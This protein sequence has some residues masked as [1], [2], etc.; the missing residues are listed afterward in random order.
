M[1]SKIQT[2]KGAEQLSKQYNDSSAPL[3]ETRLNLWLKVGAVLLVVALVV[4]WFQVNQVGTQTFALGGYWGTVRVTST[5][6]RVSTIVQQLLSL[7]SASTTSILGTIINLGLIILGFVAL[8]SILLVRKRAFKLASYVLLVLFVASVVL[9]LLQ[10]ATLSSWFLVTTST[11]YVKLG[12]FVMGATIIIFLLASFEAKEETVTTEAAKPT[13]I[14]TGTQVMRVVRC[15]ACPMG[16][17][18]REANVEA[19]YRLESPLKARSG[20]DYYAEMLRVTMNCPL[21]KNLQ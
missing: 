5:G 4:G 6:F 18:C 14:S 11:F 3:Q 12:D 19:S 20:E 2:A 10:G 17:V 15:H 9:V 16:G 21:K 1:L 8:L 7:T 13:S